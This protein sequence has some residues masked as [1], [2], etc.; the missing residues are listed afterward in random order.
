MSACVPT[1]AESLVSQLGPRF[2]N[3]IVFQMPP[4]YHLANLENWITEG[5]ALARKFRAT[6][7][8]LH[9]GWSLASY[10]VW[11]GG[12]IALTVAAFR[13]QDLN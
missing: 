10:A 12:L 13:R 5:E 7:V 9:W 6:V 8:R 3:P 11:A 2:L 1:T 4:S